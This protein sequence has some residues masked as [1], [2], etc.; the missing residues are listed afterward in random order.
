MSANEEEYFF[1]KRPYIEK[2]KFKSRKCN[3]VEKKFCIFDLLDDNKWGILKNKIV[4]LEKT[5]YK[6]FIQILKEIKDYLTNPSNPDI[7]IN[8]DE[9]IKSQIIS[10]QTEIDLTYDTIDEITF[11]NSILQKYF[12]KKRKREQEQPILK[13][14][15]QKKDFLPFDQART[16]ARSLKLLTSTDWNTWCKKN[17]RPENIP[18]VPYITYKNKGWKN[19]KHWLTPHPINYV[20]YMEAKT[21]TWESNIRTKEEWDTWCKSGKKPKTIPDNPDIVYNN[22]DSIY[23]WYNWESFLLSRNFVIVNTRSQETRQ[24]RNN[25][26]FKKNNIV[27][28]AKRQSKKI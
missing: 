1:E 20:S 7:F 17:M 18:S 4:N 23:K 10:T 16:F 9:N 25:R 22:N 28:N 5:D 21:A 14:S 3:D 13:K 12:E 6:T 19:W 8:I 26:I 15:K 27:L 2:K 24:E 11:I